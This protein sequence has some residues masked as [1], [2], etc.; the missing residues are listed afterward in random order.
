M[1]ADQLLA[2]I[3]NQARR[4]VYDEPDDSAHFEAFHWVKDESI[5]ARILVERAIIRRFVR[6][7]LAADEALSITVYNGEHYAVRNCRVL[8]EVMDAIG[9]TDEEHL[10]V[11]RR[12][13]TTGRNSKVGEIFVVYGNGGWDVMNNWTTGTT[14]LELIAGAEKLAND[15][16]D[17]IYRKGGL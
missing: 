14:M 16:C 5:R 3:K 13:P 17:A 6:D 15:L 8:F 2:S 4:A 1:N 7:V 11:L 9:Q 10:Y 12:D